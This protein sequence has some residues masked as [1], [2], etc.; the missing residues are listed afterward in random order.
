MDNST[1]NNESVLRANDILP[2][3]N[4]DRL[5]TPDSGPKTNQTGLESCVLGLGSNADIPHFN[6]AE[7]ILSE[8]R[9]ATAT[10]RSRIISGQR[11]ADRNS[12]QEKTKDD[13]RETRD[14]S[15]PV[16]DGQA[17]I[18]HHPSS[19]GNLN[20]DRII[21]EIVAKD[22]QMLRFGRTYGN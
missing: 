4:K 6:L 16:R 11:P 21:A 3:F 1:N 18:I 13:R 19:F 7:Q 2:P 9:K 20:T 12:E 17:H 8:Q 10:K 5:Q 15:S 22:I 14:G